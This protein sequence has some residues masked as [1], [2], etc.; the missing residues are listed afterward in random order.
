MN[1]SG[2]FNGYLSC[3]VKNMRPN[4]MTTNYWAFQ[5]AWVDQEGW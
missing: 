5:H 4:H 1:G 3:R 2:V